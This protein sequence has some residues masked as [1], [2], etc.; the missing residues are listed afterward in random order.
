MRILRVGLRLAAVVVAA[1]ATVSLAAR[2][3]AAL[4]DL[5]LVVVVAIGLRSGATAGAGWGLV[6]GWLVDLVPPGS[7]A[8]GSAA[9]VY[10][11]AGAFA[12]RR[13]RADRVSVAWI[14]VVSLVCAAGVQAAWVLLALARSAPVDLGQVVVDGLLTATVAAVVV[15]LAARVEHLV[16]RRG[17][18]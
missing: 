18:A 17:L 6:A 15:P 13:H 16:A 11:A 1:L 3:P 5:V 12:G 4:P 2:H 14:G 10:A 8:L 9:L 7:V